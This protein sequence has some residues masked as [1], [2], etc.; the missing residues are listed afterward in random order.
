MKNKDY[1][2]FASVADFCSYVPNVMQGISEDK[3]ITNCI[4]ATY[5]H[6]LPVISTDIYERA[7]DDYTEMLKRIVANYTAFELQQISN[8]LITESSASY[9]ESEVLKANFGEKQ[10]ALSYYSSTADRYLDQLL[11]TMQSEGEKIQMGSN[12]IFFTSLQEFEQVRYINNS[13]RTFIAM[14]SAIKMVETLRILPQIAGK[15]KEII[16]AG[17]RELYIIRALIAT[18]TILSVIDTMKIRYKD[19][20]NVATY[21]SNMEEK[22]NKEEQKAKKNQLK[23]EKIAL[24]EEFENI[25]QRIM[26]K[27]RVVFENKQENKGFI[28]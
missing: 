22:Y 25:L 7:K 12:S 10:D 28:F 4:N 11:L 9:T 26:A 15:E 1:Y 17:G 24:E 18:E 13:Y 8:M 27:Q 23:E 20:I 2:I 14:Q 3:I 21:L 19:G 6:I 16:A 5:K